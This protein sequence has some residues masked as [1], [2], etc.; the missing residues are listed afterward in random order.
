MSS[1]H[2]PH[3]HFFFDHLIPPAGYISL[4]EMVEEDPA[5]I[6]AIRQALFLQV[7]RAIL[8][9]QSINALSGDLHETITT[10]DPTFIDQLNEYEPAI[11]VIITQALDRAILE[12][13]TALR[14]T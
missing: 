4:V 14:A 7:W 5:A 8:D 13:H 12:L 6:S 9:S 11:E 2:F 1:L 10:S 3:P